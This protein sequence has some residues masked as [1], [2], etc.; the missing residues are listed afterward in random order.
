MFYP[1]DRHWFYFSY[2]PYYLI[3]IETDSKIF[4]ARYKGRHAWGEVL[5]AF[6]DE[7]LGDYIPEADMK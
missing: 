3:R 4:R 5:A 1:R 2:N 6:C 7:V